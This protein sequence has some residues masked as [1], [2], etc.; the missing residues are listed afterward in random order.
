MRIP[1]SKRIVQG[2]SKELRLDGGGEP[3][4][5]GWESKSQRNKELI[6]GNDARGKVSK[7]N[8]QKND[9]LVR[10]PGTGPG[11][12]LLGKRDRRFEITIKRGKK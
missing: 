7:E 8:H 10:G 6:L 12:E 1:R 2:V 9:R 3:G 4:E 11:D 5:E